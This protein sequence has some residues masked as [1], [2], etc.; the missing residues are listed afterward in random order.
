MFSETV[1]IVVQR[2][3]RRDR[4]R[5]IQSYVRGVIRELQ[6]HRGFYFH[7]DLTELV[8]ENTNQQL[9]VTWDRPKQLRR[10]RTVD[11]GGYIYPRFQQPVRKIRELEEYYYSASTYYVFAGTGG[12]DIN[13]AYYSYVRPLQYYPIGSRPAVFSQELQEWSYLL[14]GELVPTLGNEDAEEAARELVSHWLFED[15]QHAIEEGAL[16]KLYKETADQRAVSAFALFKSYQND[17]VSGEAFES[18]GV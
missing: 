4:L 6:V 3:G 12:E 9:N 10:L 5:D 18:L 8:I 1:D 11:Y 15:W 2:S 17:L 16:A 13:I 7:R 14:N